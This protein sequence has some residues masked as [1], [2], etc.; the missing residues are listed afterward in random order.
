MTTFWPKLSL[1]PVS[2]DIT[3][4]HPMSVDAPASGAWRQARCAQR[5]ANA[6]NLVTISHDRDGVVEYSSYGHFRTGSVRVKPGERV[7][8]GQII[9]EVG[10]N[11]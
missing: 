8:Q 9:A 4:Y 10:D 6:G 2:S 3:G 11:G 5:A 7:V 1:L